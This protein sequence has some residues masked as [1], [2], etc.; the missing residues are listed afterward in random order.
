[1][2]IGGILMTYQFMQALGLQPN[3]CVAVVGSGGKSSLIKEIANEASQL[4]WPTVITTTTHIQ[5]PFWK[6]DEN[7]LML[8]SARGVEKWKNYI[9]NTP[10][11]VLCQPQD[12]TSQ[13]VVVISR[14]T[15]EHKAVGVSSQWVEQQVGKHLFLV[16]ADGSRQLPWKIPS[17]WEPVVPQCTTHT[18]IV[19]GAKALSKPLISTYVHRLELLEQASLCPPGTITIELIAEILAYPNYYRSKIPCNSHIIVY[20]AGCEDKENIKQWLPLANELQQYG[21]HWPLFAGELQSENPW[22]KRVEE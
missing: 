22:I 21:L 14:K 13:T 5:I 20:I 4:Y 17:S 2:A 6:D 1:M 8:H 7:L 12:T 9:V 16:E 18:V 10:Q 15:S 3:S 11:A 19:V